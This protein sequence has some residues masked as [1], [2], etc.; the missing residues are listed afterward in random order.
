MAAIPIV[1]DASPLAADVATIDALAR[2]RLTARRR[3]RGLTLQGA[4]PELLELI[5]F[6]GL[7]D[8]LRVEPRGQAEQREEPLR[9]EEEG[10]LG[11]SSI[12][13]LEDL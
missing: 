3:G 5:T 12:G 2:L 10:E 11:D 6:V 8:V 7:R 9:V 1:L 4:S 13:D